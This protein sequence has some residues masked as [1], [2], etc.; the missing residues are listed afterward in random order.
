MN[1]ILKILFHGIAVFV[2]AYFIK[3]ISV[4]NFGYALLVGLVLTIINVTIKPILQILTL[5]VTILTLG[6]FLLVIN[7]LMVLLAAYLVPQ[8]FSVNG[9]WT[10]ML[11]SVVVTLVYSFLSLF[12]KD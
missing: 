3:G 7:A 12:L 8:W 6:F 2:A 9:F 4:R 10:A 5:P 1:T 11:F